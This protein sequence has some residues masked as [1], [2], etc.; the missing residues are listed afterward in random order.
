MKRPLLA[1]LFACLCSGAFAGGQDN[2]SLPLVTKQAFTLDS[3]TTYTG[4]RL[5]QVRV[6]WESYG[7]LNQDKSN[8]ILIT[9][10]FSATSH[11]AGKYRTSDPAPGYWDAII[12]PGKAIDTNKYFVLS[13]D[14]LVNLYP[15]SAD[16][17][18]TGPATINPDT[19]KPYGLDFPVVTI[20][21]FVN[22]QAALLDSLGIQRLHAVMGPSMGGLQSLDWGLAHPERVERVVSVIGAGAM[23]A[24]SLALLETWTSPIKAD[25]N[26]N[27][28]DYY[29]STPPTEG[30]MASLMLITRDALNP[31]GY[32]AL[33]ADAH[34]LEQA[35]LMDIRA[36]YASTA[37]LKARAKSRSK[38]ADANHLL[39]LVRASQAY[40]AGF[41]Q[42]L[43]KGLDKLR[44]RVLLMPAK[45]DLLLSPSLLRHTHGL[46]QAK[47][48]DS[49]LL[50]MDLPD[51]LGHLD[52]VSRIQAYADEIRRFID[53]PVTGTIDE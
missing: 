33:K 39:Y 37:W 17:I 32:N 53:A 43:E 7:T 42:S 35:P 47:G 52:G 48:K 21:D 27:N 8:A 28:G 34:P 22:V 24:W 29:H 11:A 20:R 36:D 2:R 46:L 12:G 9:H 40:M 25:D 14:S 16:V 15:F 3:F 4:Q 23:D 31:A 41:E 51:T 50:E 30:L 6:G 18:T 5:K 10:Y 19:N 13:V 45:G 38:D 49:T 26:W 44:A 1:F